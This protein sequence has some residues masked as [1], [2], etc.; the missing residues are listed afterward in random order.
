MHNIEYLPL[1]SV[2]I[3]VYKVEKYLAGTIESV[4]NQ[5]YENIEIILVNDGSPDNC[6]SICDGYAQKYSNIQVIHKL[7]GGLSEARNFGIERANGNYVLFLDSDDQLVNN[8][9][10]ELVNVAKKTSAEIIIPDRYIKINEITKVE[11][12]CFHFNIL[13]VSETPIE[14]AL[15]T[16]ISKARA[17]RAT[18]VLYDLS[19]IKTKDIRFPVG[20]IAED[21]VFNMLIFKV[22]NKIAF[23]KGVTLLNLNRSGSITTTFQENLGDVFL[24]IDGKIREFLID[25]GNYN[26]LGIRKKNELLCRNTIIFISSIFSS[27]CGWSRPKK[28]EVAN[29]FLKRKIIKEAFMITSINPYFQSKVKIIYVKIMFFLIKY[30]LFNTA[31]KFTELMRR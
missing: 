27:K 3:P 15:N 18:A 14:F 30:K 28:V 11:K 19:I 20:Y 9:V 7:N 5:T 17:W 1:V 24:F 25:T 13:K 26:E 12:L 6:P 4:L 10:T 8:S 22:V 29:E 31:Y 16:L 21:I 2:V 23:Y